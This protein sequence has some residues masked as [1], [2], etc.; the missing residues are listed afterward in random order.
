MV[1]VGAGPTSQYSMSKL[2]RE[3]GW[4]TI[5]VEP[6]PYYFELHKNEG[7]EIYQYAISNKI[8]NNQDFEIINP[9][10]KVQMA[11]SALKLKYPKLINDP[12]KIIKVDI[13]TLNWL[14]EFLNIDKT[15]YVSIDVEGWELEVMKGFDVKKYNPKVIVLENLENNKL[16]NEYMNSIEYKLFKKIYVNDIYIH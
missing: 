8:L 10:T 15:D 16:Y 14:L 2:F 1:E 6:N 13:V 9:E 11:G 4:R 7:N 3:N 5:C 12:K